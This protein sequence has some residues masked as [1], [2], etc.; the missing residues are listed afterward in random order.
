M[1]RLHSALVLLVSLTTVSLASAVEPAKIGDRAPDLTFKDIRYLTRSLDDFPGK[2]AYVLAF[3]T[4]GCPVA[5]HYLPTLK[6]LDA[7]YRDKG[8]QFLAVQR[9]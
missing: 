3:V 6:R 1:C 4:T 9:A 2:K 7:D 8:V 5:A